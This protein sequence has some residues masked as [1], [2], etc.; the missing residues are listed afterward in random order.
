MKR[1][2][3]MAETFRMLH[4]LSGLEIRILSKLKYEECLKKV[5]ALLAKMNEQG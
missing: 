5:K 1:E 3:S 2:N 4:G